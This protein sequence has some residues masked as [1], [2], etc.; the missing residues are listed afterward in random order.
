MRRQPDVAPEPTSA[1]SAQVRTLY[2]K[3]D[4]S[5]F[6]AVRHRLNR[7]RCPGESYKLAFTPG[8]LDIFQAKASPADLT[9]ILTGA[10]GA[11]RDLDG[12]GPLW[13]PSGQVFYSPTTGDSAPSGARLRAGAFLS[14]ASLPG[15]VRQRRPSVDL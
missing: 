3:N 8:L 4:L 12:D 13:I 2:R 5:G 10:E 9:A 1:S 14:A 15:S 6:S 7:W 11:I